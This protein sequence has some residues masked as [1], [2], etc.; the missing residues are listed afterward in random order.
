[1]PS[2]IHEKLMIEG[3]R[4]WIPEG[5]EVQDLIERELGIQISYP[6]WDSSILCDAWNIIHEMPL[7]LKMAVRAA[8]GERNAEERKN[9]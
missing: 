1:M 9:R 2:V 8:V 5:I 3:Q 4:A 6:N 7:T